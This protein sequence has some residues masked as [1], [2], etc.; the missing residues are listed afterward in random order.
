MHPEM[1][2]VGLAAI[3]AGP[4]LFRSAARIG[5]AIYRGLPPRL[6]RRGGVGTPRQ[7]RNMVRI[8]GV[9]AVL[10]GALMVI[11]SFTA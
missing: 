2:L 5:P 8:I 10:W 11:A 6:L 7:Q 9:F 1:L 3:L 4:F